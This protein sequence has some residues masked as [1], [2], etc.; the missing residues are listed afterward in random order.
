MALYN[1]KNWMLKISRKMLKR[2]AFK[3]F[4]HEKNFK[5]GRI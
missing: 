4:F 1:L 5:S 2:S 3:K